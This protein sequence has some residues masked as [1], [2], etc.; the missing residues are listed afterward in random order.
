M[1]LA[2]RKMWLFVGCCCLIFGCLAY[3]YTRQDH[4][5]ESFCLIHVPDSRPWPKHATSPAL[6]YLNVQGP[7]AATL[8]QALDLTLERQGFDLVDTPAQAEG[9]VQVSVIHA[10]EA[11]ETSCRRAVAKGYGVQTVVEGEGL[12]ALIYDLLLVERDIAKERDDKHTQLATISNR[13][14][15]GSTRMRLGLMTYGKTIKP[16]PKEVAQGAAIEMTKII[17]GR[18]AK[19]H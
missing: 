19:K 6:I 4:E 7:W 10:G 2:D 13:H 9:I 15:R 5:V 8:S 3:W 16:L 11:T 1:H 12:G 18:F 17:V 14:I